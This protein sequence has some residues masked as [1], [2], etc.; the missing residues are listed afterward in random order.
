MLPPNTAPLADSIE[1]L[2]KFHLE[3]IKLLEE[4]LSQLT[5]LE[6]PLQIRKICNDIIRI[7]KTLEKVPP[8]E[9]K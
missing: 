8:A 4:E 3:K 5:I 1:V 6:H 2:R 7:K 9:S